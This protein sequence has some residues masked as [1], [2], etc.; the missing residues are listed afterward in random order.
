MKSALVAVVTRIRPYKWPIAVAVF[1]ALGLALRLYAAF[2]APW[3]WD[4][5]YLTEYAKSLS[6]GGPAQ[7]GATRLSGLFGAPFSVVVPLSAAPLAALPGLNALEAARLWASLLAAL[8]GLLLVLLA[9]RSFGRV[10]ALWAAAL[11]A[12]WPMAVR[13]QCLAFYHPLGAEAALAAVCAVV[14]GRPR[15]AAGLAGLAAICCYWLWW[16]P[17]LVVAYLTWRR[18]APWAWLL[19]FAALAPLMDLAVVLGAGWDRLLMDLHALGHVS[20]AS[21]PSF[22]RP[23]LDLLGLDFLTLPFLP[24]GL[25]GLGLAWRLRRA[26]GGHELLI[27]AVALGSVLEP[28]RQRGDLRAMH[29]PL[30]PAIPFICLGVAW[31]AARLSA[32]RPAQLL[33]LGVL[34]TAFAW[35]SP[36]VLHNALS[37]DPARAREMVAYLKRTLAPQAQVVGMVELNWALRPELQPYEAAE[38]AAVQGLPGGF[39]PG[40]LTPDHFVFLPSLEKTQALIVSRSN[41]LGI[42]KQ[43]NTAMLYL[44]A[45]QAGWPKSFDNRSF[46]VYLNPRYFKAKDPDVRILQGAEF[47][48]LAAGQLDA[49]GDTAAAAFARRHLRDAVPAP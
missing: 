41:V 17:V 40:G 4:E 25:L 34:L 38:A 47:Y 13:Y 11:W 30:I 35:P 33:G 19:L 15:L 46:R 10:E 14:Y 18:A 5:G 29:Y 23:A 7:I 9:A 48:A 22:P 45:E 3:Y 39:L 27:L 24:A 6:Q 16:L 31:L 36:E 26:R 1:L 37:A 32:W 20:Q 2:H 44:R 43:A 12:L 42:F 8:G 28:W 21:T 49:L